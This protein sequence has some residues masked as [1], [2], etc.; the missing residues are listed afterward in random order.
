MS[1]FPPLAATAAD[2]TTYERIDRF[3][4]DQMSGSR[5]PGAALAIVE[6]DQI[7]H[8]QGFGDSGGTAITPQTPFAIGSLTKSFTALSIMQLVEA[9]KVVLDAPVQQYVAWF[10]VADADAS[11]QITVRQLLNQTS[12][13]SR[14][15]GIRP[16]LEQRSETIEQYVRSLRD[17]DLNRPV[18]ESYEY[19]NAN[20]VTLG[21]IVETVSGQHYGD[22]IREHIFKPLDMRASYTSFDE[23]RQNGMSDLHQFWFGLPIATQTPNL[24][25]LIPA[26]FLVASAED[27]AHYLSM[28]LN[29]GAYQG[30]QILSPAGI[31]AMLAPATNEFQ[32]TL[33]GTEFTAR[34]GMGWFTGPFGDTPALWH[35]GELPTFN[36]WMIVLP[37]TNQA[38]VVLINA[39]NQVPIAGANEVFSRIPIGITQI[40]AGNEPP[41]GMSLTRFYFWFDLIALAI[42]G[43]QTWRLMRL[44]RYPSAR[45]SRPRSLALALQ[46]A[47]RT[48][49]LVWEIGLSI[50]IFAAVPMLTGVGW[51]GN[52]TS[53]PDLVI[54]L[55]M[56]SGL[57]L[58][59]GLVRIGKL[60]GMAIPA[61]RTA[62]PH[63]PRIEASAG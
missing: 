42:V 17:A 32:R 38:V 6:G 48:I 49:P 56:I 9:G 53:T 20:Y 16:L 13:L 19:S 54:V 4:T 28:Y 2:A 24:P 35:L 44:L 18:G 10:E 1:L 51:R 50:L 33:L 37:E 47:R 36:A 57:W 11:A 22:Y 59:A 63:P 43:I 23:G 41:S 61:R 31:R 39:G 29:D 34:Y 26:G 21:L 62:Q 45:L 55:L 3:V 27:M 14:A 7:S 60:A 52:F 25:S 40:L 58:A 8:S 5:I 12:G 46:V 15:T 30:R